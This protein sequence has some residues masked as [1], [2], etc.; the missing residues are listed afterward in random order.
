MRQLTQIARGFAALLTL[1]ALL[2]ACGGAGQPA[3][4]PTSASAG[5][6]LPAVATFSILGDLVR[7]VGGDLVE[8]A[9][10]V[11]PGGDAHT[12]EPT[13]ADSGRLA[14]ANVIFENGLAFESWLDDL[15]TA[16]GSQ[17]ARVVV[18]KGVAAVAAAGEHGQAGTD[19]ADGELDPHIWHDVQNTIAMVENIRAGLAAADP[20]NAAAYQANADAYTA[21]LKE[22]DAFIQGQVSQIPAERRRLVTSHD[23]FEYFARRYGLE[24]VGTALGAVSTEAAD[25][26]ASEIAALVQDIKAA[27]VPAIFAENVAN[28]GLME[29]I[30]GEAGVTLAPTLYTDALGDPGSGGATYIEMMRYN[31]TTIAGA[32]KG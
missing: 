31:A 32:L 26:P 27:G 1:T 13:P 6:R 12:F 29:T 8:V 18:S 20:A 9:V 24:I 10:L 2:S 17:A 22:L 15:Y 11:G 14:G 3:S 23:T 21:K 16:S 7:N 5:R 4:A 28:P 19:H 30:A 25:P